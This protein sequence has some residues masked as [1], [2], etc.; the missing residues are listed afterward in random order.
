VRKTSE[1]KEF[2]VGLECGYAPFNWTQKDNSNGAVPIRGSKEYAGGYDVEI[3]KM[4]ADGLGRDLVIVKTAW[5]GL[6]P[7]VQSAL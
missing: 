4:I 2:K 7:A 6:T 3:A 5:A 1:K